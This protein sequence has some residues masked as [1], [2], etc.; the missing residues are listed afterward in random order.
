MA[1]LSAA[2]AA[3]GV[4]WLFYLSNL[5]V[6]GVLLFTANTSFGG[7]PVLM[8]LLA[9]DHRLPHL[10][11][12]RAERPVFRYG[13]SSLAVL[14]ALLLVVVGANTNRAAAAVRD[15][16]V[17][18]LHHQPGRAGSAL[19]GAATTGLG[20]AGR[21]ER[22]RCHADRRRCR[23]VLPV[24]IRRRGVAAAAHRA[25]LD[26]VARQPSNVTTAGPGRNW[27]LFRSPLSQI[28][29]SLHRRW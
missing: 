9:K 2:A 5:S 10:C 17:H 3:F 11:G 20:R 4:G 25:R 19:A 27:V 7:L 24:E 23:G 16:G 13:V 6:T 8:G 28:L 18:R 12:L 26:L 15:R 29:P 21:V 1:Q 14:A 22:C